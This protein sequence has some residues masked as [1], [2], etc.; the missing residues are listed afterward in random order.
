MTLQVRI[1]RSASQEIARKLLK[2]CRPL[3]YSED[4]LPLSEC[5]H[6]ELRWDGIRA[7]N[8]S[9]ACLAA[10]EVQMNSL[11]EMGHNEYYR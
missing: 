5:L 2:V 7:L 9:A 10:A 1:Y 3:A 6:L 8:F 11:D 4:R